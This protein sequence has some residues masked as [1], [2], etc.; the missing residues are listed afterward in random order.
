MDEIKRKL[1]LIDQQLSGT[2]F[3]RNITG[4]CPL[5]FAAAGLITGILIQNRIN[6]PVFTWSIFLI[7][8]A[9]LSIIMF[10]V[11]RRP[12]KIKFYLAYISLACFIC[13]GAIRL[14]N[15]NMPRS[16]D[17]RNITSGEPTLA[18]IRGLVISEPHININRQ[19]K[20]SEFTPTD[21]TSSFYFKAF[22][23]KTKTR[24]EKICGNVF[25]H[26]DEPVHDLKA[27]DKIQ[28]FCWLDRFEPP[29]NPGQFDI[30]GYMT[31]R[32]I[33]VTA[34]I[35]SRD[36]IL[37]LPKSPA[38][39]ATGFRNKI[40]QLATQA[41]LNDIPDEDAGNGLLQALLLGY[42]SDIDS[43]TYEAFRKTGLLHFI[44][45]SGMHLGILVGIVWWL[46]KIIGLL[47]PARAVV[48]AIAVCIFLV[49][50]PLR[51]PTL[52]AAI[53]CWVFCASFIFRRHSNPVN[54]LSLAAI[55]LLLI[56]PTQL[57]EAGWQLS[58]A[59]VLGII[60][61]TERIETFASEHIP[62]GPA[63]RTISKLHSWVLRLFSVGFAA[64]LGGAGILLYHFF[65]ITPLTSIWTVLVFPLVCAVLTIGFSKM[66][67]Y[68]LFP[69][70]SSVLAV[71]VLQISNILIWLVKFIAQLNI[72]E[73]LIGHVSVYLIILYYC[74][75]IIVL[76][77]HP[78]FARLKKTVITTMLLTTVL[79]LGITKYQR[80]YRNNLI[81]TCLDV[82]QG[83]AILAQL[84]GRT[85][86]L[87]DAGS[88]YKSNVGG[89]TV[90]PFLN[91]I[92][93]TNIDAV[94]ISHNDID[95]INGIPEI[96]KYRKVGSIYA[97]D[98]F[99][100]KKD[101]WGT[102]QFLEECLAEEGFTLK[103]LDK[104][105]NLTNDTRINFLW[106]NEQT[107]G[108]EDLSDNDQSLVS[109]IDFAGVK[110]LLCSDIENYG[111]IELLKLY[112]SLKAD[113]VVVPHHGSPNTLEKDFLEKLD[114]NIL[115]CS[116]SR[117]QYERV[118]YA[119]TLKNKKLFFTS[120][121]GAISVR[122]D[123]SGMI[124]T[125]TYTNKAMTEKTR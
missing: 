115:I 22:E 12:T 18:T 101:V 92:G 106:P 81:L 42:R 6:L 78:R 87:F 119:G 25:V 96:V 41:M 11:R 23:V 125:A 16:D 58:F 2:D 34:S 114:A 71:V 70:I 51:A 24:W 38:G 61:L 29:T 94:I 4:T 52:R 46:C 36:G 88:M 80:T 107:A 31:R 49:I 73:I 84:P 65:T 59:T 69:T 68:Y 95:H 67:L 15:F 86:I 123:K 10:L 55:I 83:Q 32:N 74:M 9:I 111:Q 33:F 27:G 109:S 1:A 93:I 85:N 103:R 57:F 47:K 102:A 63:H 77:Q 44:S 30:A 17:I 108:N 60:L 19:W 40:R 104:E 72:S 117:S 14:N 21:P 3:H 91:Y 35:K 110:I 62:S 39:I 64:W 121:D 99:F 54:T 48:C 26:V 76:Y 66:V 43:D 20:F 37:L 122:I 7:V 105:W 100:N 75:I 13:L 45:L 118:D 56:R 5:L 116:C 8:S 113:I 89:R 82:G 97:N 124:T 120:E 79:C 53:I 90:I 28:L 112:P 98:A 50:V